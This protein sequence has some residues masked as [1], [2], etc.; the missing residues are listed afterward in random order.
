[1]IDEIFTWY[2]S[3]SN[4]LRSSEAKMGIL[5]FRESSKPKFSEVVQYLDTQNELL[6]KGSIF[7]LQVV[8]K[9]DL[10]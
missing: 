2:E 1:M 10:P 3:V 8:R 7:P 9:V 5:L 6:G 4:Q